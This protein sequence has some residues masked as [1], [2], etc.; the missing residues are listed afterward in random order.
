MSVEYLCLL[1]GGAHRGRTTAGR[2]SLRLGGGDI[3]RRVGAQAHAQAVHYLV[4]LVREVADGN[5]QQRWE[6]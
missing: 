6:K 2:N 4:L 1:G 5:L 3:A